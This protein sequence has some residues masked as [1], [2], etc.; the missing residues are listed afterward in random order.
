MS[1]C[2]TRV[3]SIGLF[4]KKRCSLKVPVIPLYYSTDVCTGVLVLYHLFIYSN[5]LC[6]SQKQEFTYKSIR[7]LDESEIYIR[8]SSNWR[9]KCQI[10]VLSKLKKRKNPS[11][12]ACA[13]VWKMQSLFSHDLTKVN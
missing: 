6:I 11:L 12:N 7:V 13:K 4:N 1:S 10:R 9:Q 3:R 8:I 5:T 2:Q